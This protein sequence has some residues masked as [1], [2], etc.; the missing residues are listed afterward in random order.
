MFKQIIFSMLVASVVA[1]SIP[2]NSFARDGGDGGDV[3]D[4]SE[5]NRSDDRQ[6]QENQN[7]KQKSNPFPRLALDLCSF[8]IPGT[9]LELCLDSRL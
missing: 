2:S 4:R 8:R 3:H 5:H 1:V 9:A 6:D 7:K